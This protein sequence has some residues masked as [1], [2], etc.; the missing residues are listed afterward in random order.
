MVHIQIYGHIP[1][2]SI[3]GKGLFQCPQR[4]KE[5]FYII[6]ITIISRKKIFWKIALSFRK[7][8]ILLQCA[9]SLEAT[10]LAEG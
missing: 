9:R 7:Y 6:D 8:H 5:T 10:L 1:F 2:S 3:L 4:I